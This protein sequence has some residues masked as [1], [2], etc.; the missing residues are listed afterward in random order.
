M[1]FTDTELAALAQGYARTGTDVLTASSGP[2]ALAI[3]DGH[4]G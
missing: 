4:S 2:F 3:L 1:Q